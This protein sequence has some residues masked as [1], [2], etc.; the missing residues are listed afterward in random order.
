MADIKPA[1]V[2]KLRDATAAGMKE[3]KNALIEANGDFH[4]A[5]KILKKKGLAAAGKRSGR[6][7]NEGLIFIAN[8]GETAVI[9]EMTCETHFVAQNEIFQKFGKEIAELALAEKSSDPLN[10]KIQD[11]LK[12]AISIIKEN[13][14][15]KKINIIEGDASSLIVEYSHDGGSIG[16]V[17]K[18]SAEDA[19]VISNDEVKQF[20]FDAALHIA[21]FNPSYLN[22]ESVDEDYRA[23]QLDIFT[24][25]AKNLGKPEKIIEGI[26]KGK[27]NKHFSEICLLKQDFVKDDKKSVEKALADISKTVGST[28]SIAEY[29]YM[30]VGAE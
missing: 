13:M 23:D 21:A 25:Q 10:E 5:Q 26:V 9:L 6:A 19:S 22:V 2:K 30:K 8:N 29:S 11:K 7:T 1:D 16:A 24:T 3:C 4:E 18:I 27:L 15:I 17:V 20:A 28:L 12:E 14:L